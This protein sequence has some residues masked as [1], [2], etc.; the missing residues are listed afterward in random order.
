MTRAIKLYKSLDYVN[1]KDDFKQYLDCYEGDQ[2]VMRKPE[3][4]IEHELETKT[5]GKT[6]RR[7]REQRSAYV[8]LCEPIV[9]MWLSLLFRKEMTIPEEVLTLLGDFVDDID[10]RGSSFESFCRD[11]IAK[12]YLLYGRPIVYIT[13]LGEKPVTLKDELTAYRPIF[14]LIE[15][16]AFVDYS[17]EFKDVG[18]IGSLNFCRIEWEEI[19][20]RSNPTQPIKKATRTKLFWLEDKKLVTQI[21]EAES[22]EKTEVSSKDE[23]KDPRSWKPIE[24]P[25]VVSDWDEIPITAELDS[26]SWVKDV[27]PHILKYFNL[28]SVL[29]NICLF[30]AYQ[31]IFIASDNMNK[32]DSIRLAEYALTILPSD[33]NVQTVESV[34]TSG[35][36][37]RLSQVLNN[38]FRIAL[39]QVRQTSGESK[40]AEAADTQ[41]EQKD[42][43][44]A[45]IQSEAEAIENIINHAVRLFAKYY[46]KE[47]PKERVKIN[48]PNDVTDADIVSKLVMAFKDELGE[49]P[50]FKQELM[51]WF[52]NRMNLEKKTE[53][54]DEIESSVV[55]TSQRG[56]TTENDLRANLL[57]GINE[58]QS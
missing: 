19:L 35:L 56:V 15:P 24:D 21:F 55:A 16:L 39:N 17:R 36:E 2:K 11:A 28:E 46:N 34:E 8:N 29:D 18:R 33:A 14:K 9:S 47:A 50:V 58:P 51:K 48:V 49:L 10:G 7:I 52:A 1:L 43:M 3:Y 41:K 26:E 38:I 54:F 42:M 57:A 6:I 31:K 12:N 37:K 25:Q 23:T 4:L 45:L 30:Q 53:I 27:I 13:S 20:E 40:A 5:A 22:E 44:L 32:D